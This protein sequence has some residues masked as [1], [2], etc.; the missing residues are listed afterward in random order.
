MTDP[1]HR[2]APDTLRVLDRRVPRDARAGV[3]T[4]EA[5]AP[6]A[7]CVEDAEQIRHQ[8]GEPVGGDVLG[9]AGR[10]VTPQ[11][12]G[13]DAKAR[14]GE[15]GDLV[16]PRPPEFGLTVEEHDGLAVVRA[17]DD[18]VDANAVE[19]EPARLEVHPELGARDRHAVDGSDGRSRAAREHDAQGQSRNSA[20][21]AP[22]EVDPVARVDAGSHPRSTPTT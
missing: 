2:Q 12:G 19:V 7:E 18:R 4:R 10:V 21:G 11:V 9:L 3:V 13:H 5:D 15:G 17:G 8:H 1:E 22:H 16:A 14:P 6:V 20:T